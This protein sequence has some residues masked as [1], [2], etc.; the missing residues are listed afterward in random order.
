[1]EG[2]DFA[3]LGGVVSHQN[4]FA[5]RGRKSAIDIAKSV[6]AH[7]IAVD[8]ARSGDLHKKV[9]Q[10]FEP[11]GQA[12]QETVLESPDLRGNAR[13]AMRRMM[14]TE[15]KTIYCG[16]LLNEPLPGWRVRA[17][18]FGRW[19]TIVFRLSNTG[20]GLQVTLITARGRTG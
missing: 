4:R 3:H 10:R 1:M 7:A 19:K 2:H 20:V 6:E 14:I 16:A 18:G 9:V 5:D 12:W 8:L 11:A 17:E 13:A 15:N